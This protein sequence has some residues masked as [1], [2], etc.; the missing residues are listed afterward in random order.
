MVV[1]DMKSIEEEA[2]MAR[3]P[4]LTCKRCGHEWVP[5][6]SSPAV[7]PKCHSPYWNK[8]PSPKTRARKKKR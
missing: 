2:D 1:Q 7:C 5:R 3:I 8:P 6:I 4:I